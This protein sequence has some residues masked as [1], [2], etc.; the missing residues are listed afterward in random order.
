M[1]STLAAYNYDI[2]NWSALNIKPVIKQTNHVTAAF[3]G[4]YPRSCPWRDSSENQEAQKPRHE[5]NPVGE[6]GS[7]LW[8]TWNVSCIITKCWK[9]PCYCCVRDGVLIIKVTS[10]NAPEHALRHGFLSTFALTKDQGGKLRLS[11][12]KGV[13]S[14]TITHT[15]WLNSIL[16]FRW[17]AS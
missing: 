2:Q 1:F 3:R 13:L 7:L 12:K 4:T 17:W 10:D 9:A 14:V 15:R 8:M 11:K 6:S 5:I 16:Y